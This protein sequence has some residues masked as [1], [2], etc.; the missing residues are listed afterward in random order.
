[1]DGPP[2]AFLTMVKKI[3]RGGLEGGVVYIYLGRQAS[4]PAGTNSAR[5]VYI[6]WAADPAE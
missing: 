6:T 3:Y 4:I 5:W 1:M 2:V